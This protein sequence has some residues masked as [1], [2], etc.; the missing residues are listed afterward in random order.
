MDRFSGAKFRIALHNIETARETPKP[1]AEDFVDQ[2]LKKTEQQNDYSTTFEENIEQIAVK[3]EIRPELIDQT[4]K[5]KYKCYKRGCRKTFQ[6]LHI[7]FEHTKNH[8][9]NQKELACPEPGCNKKFL[10]KVRLRSHM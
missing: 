7:L 5:G 8:H 4:N 1:E 6:C 9:K 2:I 3:T 10:T